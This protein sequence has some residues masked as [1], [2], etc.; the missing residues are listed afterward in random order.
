[1]WWAELF[2]KSHLET[3]QVPVRTLLHIEAL[4]DRGSK[5]KLEIE[6]GLR[7]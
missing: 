3:S 6:S 2:A 4:P 1:M 5:I 7:N